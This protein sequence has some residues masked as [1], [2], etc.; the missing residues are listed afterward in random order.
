MQPKTR[1]IVEEFDLESRQLFYE[2]K[3][4]KKKEQQKEQIILKDSTPFHVQ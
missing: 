2:F 1:R 4:I 3:R